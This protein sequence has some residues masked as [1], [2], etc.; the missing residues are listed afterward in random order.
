MS[1]L[2]M[3]PFIASHAG[4]LLGVVVGKNLQYV[5]SQL[6]TTLLLMALFSL[7]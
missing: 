7:A 3:N 1:I 6:E 2:P 5:F 4:G